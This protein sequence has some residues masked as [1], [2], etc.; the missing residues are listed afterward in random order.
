MTCFAVLVRVVCS[1][2]LVRVRRHEE[3]P[4]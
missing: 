3:G 1:V 4:H 2:V